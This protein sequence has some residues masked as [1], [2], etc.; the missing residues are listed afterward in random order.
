MADYGTA[1]QHEH[2][3]RFE[4]IE[5]KVGGLERDMVALEEFRERVDED[6]YNH[7]KSGM[8]TILTE[9]VA[10]HKATQE[11]RKRSESR[12]RFWLTTVLAILTVA[13]A[14]IGVLEAN[15]QATHGLLRLPKIHAHSNPGPVYASSK[16]N[17]ELAIAEDN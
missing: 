1:M 9:F 3:R 15:R 4:T 16:S 17:R 12:F 6:L 8:K 2:L 5:T 10:A 7:G 13:V 14:V 11:E